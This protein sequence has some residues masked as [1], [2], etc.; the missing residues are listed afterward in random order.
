MIHLTNLNL[1]GLELGLV[2]PHQQAPM[3]PCLKSLILVDAYDPTREV[4]YLED[5]IFSGDA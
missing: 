1:S 3:F 4:V 2:F 5:L